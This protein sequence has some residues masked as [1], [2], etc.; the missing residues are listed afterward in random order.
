M[1]N[2]LFSG[3]C[4][5]L[6]TPFINNDL[7]YPLVFRLLERQI[8]AGIDAVVLAGTTGEAPTLTDKEKIQ[9]FRSA[10]DFVGNQCKIIAG[11]GSNDTQHAIALSKAAQDVGADGLLVVTPYYNK[12]NPDGLYTHYASIADS[13]EIPIIIYNVPS[14]TSVDTPVH[15]YQQLSLIPNIAGIKEASTDIGKQSRTHAACGD[16]LSIWAGND[17]QVVPS[18]AL[19]GKGVISV[20]SNVCP[21]EVNAMTKAALI[22]DF[23]SAA[24]LQHRLTGLH[25]LLFAD[26]NPIPVKYAMKCV[27][28]DCGNCRLPLTQPT[29]ELQHRIDTYFH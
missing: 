18:I 1:K 21:V 25:E 16:K 20:L 6:V 23:C 7:N 22:G 8:D 19:G 26:V 15:V 27:G 4:T 13:V 24:A 12:A 14:R 2:P 3:V 17:D 11:T 29:K 5:A 9:L 10:K 28:Y